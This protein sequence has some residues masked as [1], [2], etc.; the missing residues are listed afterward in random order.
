MAAD[1]VA[2]QTTR[3]SL[4]CSCRAPWEP[5][6]SLQP[7]PQKRAQQPAMS[8]EVRRRHGFCLRREC[9]SETDTVPPTYMDRHVEPHD[10]SMSPLLTS[11]MSSSNSNNMNHAARCR[12]ASRGQLPSDRC[13]LRG[14]HQREGRLDATVALKRETERRWQS[15]AS[16]AGPPT[17]PPSRHSLPV[18]EETADFSQC[19]GNSHSL[20]WEVTTVLACQGNQRTRC[21]WQAEETHW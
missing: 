12:V 10:Y 4:Y 20:R 18:E 19:T 13:R 9:C 7:L 15:E 16:G 1:S 8:E 11:A 5:V 2:S 21:V 6:P 14:V 17:P 3:E